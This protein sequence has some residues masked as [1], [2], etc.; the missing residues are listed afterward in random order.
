MLVHLDYNLNRINKYR[1]RLLI[2]RTFRDWSS[3]V[4]I[5]ASHFSWSLTTVPIG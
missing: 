2:D 3:I 1:Y 5:Y 4:D